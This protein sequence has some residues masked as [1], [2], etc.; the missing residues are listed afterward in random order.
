VSGLE[1]AA[2]AS[3]FVAAALQSAV[4]FGFGLVCAPL[5]FAAFGPQQAVGL[6]TV[7]G[8]E[9]N[10]MTL[11]GEGR[12]PAPLWRLVG[13]VVAWA[14]PGMFVGVAVLRNVDAVV[15]QIALTVAVFAS[16]LV[17]WR[18]P[19][20]PRSGAWTPLAGL[21]AGL[22]TTTTSANGPPLV[23]LLVGRELDPVRVRD[24]LTTAFA[25]LNLSG[26]AVLAATGT[27]GAV[28]PAAAL[29]ALV[30][31]AALGQIAGRPLFARLAGGHYEPVLVGV[32][33]VSAI[34]GLL[35]AVL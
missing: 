6:L 20:R 17:R 22:M 27:R 23:L 5:V 3:V 25:G 7:V 9:V 12:R 32:L 16:L 1:V 21:T 8:L 14:T 19:A 28:P 24:T 2:A 11:L 13:L 10:L 33:S 29:V 26:A 15:L 34:V 4:G 18:T 31:L 35:S 30:P